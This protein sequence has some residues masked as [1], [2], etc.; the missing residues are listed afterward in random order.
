M[1]LRL[2]SIG[3]SFSANALRYLPL[4]VRSSGSARLTI[5]HA[6]IGGCSLE[7]HLKLAELHETDPASPEGSPYRFRG[8]A[9]SLK[10]ML[11]AE[12]WDCVTIQ[13]HSWLSITPETF[14]PFARELCGYAG[15]Y[16]PGAEIILH[17]TWAYRSDDTEHYK[18]GFTQKKMW[19]AVGE[20]YKG[21][22]EE[23]GIKRIIPTGDAFQKV[24]ETPEWRFETDKNFDFKHPVWPHVPDQTHSLHIGHRWTDSPN[25]PVF[26]FDGRHANMAG[27]FLGGCVWFCSLFGMDVRKVRFKPARLPARDAAFLKRAAYETVFG[28]DAATR[29]SGSA[30]GSSPSRS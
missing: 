4:I 28:A 2:F 5:G 16:A 10:E 1:N 14:R 19:R 29:G 9:A 6:M 23:L 12:K 30:R 21:I 18:D 22:A 17:Q 8:K 15:R 11:S 27:E 3:N 24:C 25:G 7:K 26:G 20:S 13:Q